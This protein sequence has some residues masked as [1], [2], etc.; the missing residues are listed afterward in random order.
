MAIAFVQDEHVSSTAVSQQNIVWGSNTT[1]GSTIIVIAGASGTQT[2]TGVSDSQTN[3]YSQVISNVGLGANLEIWVCYGITGGTTPTVTIDWSASNNPQT[4]IIEYSGVLSQDAEPGE[5]SADSSS[6][7]DHVCNASNLTPSEDNCMVVGAMRATG[8]IGTLSNL[9]SGYVQR[10]GS[11]GTGAARC[12]IIDNIQTTATA[13][14]ASFT[15][16]GT[17]SGACAMFIVRA[18]SAGKVTKN[19]RGWGL[20]MELGVNLWGQ[21]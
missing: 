21:N 7:T 19:I 6:L 10:T 18:S 15:S 5:G 4:Y 8:N 17:V 12:I 11:D 3:S 9:E 20:G 1:S 16:S 13:T 2:V 14:D